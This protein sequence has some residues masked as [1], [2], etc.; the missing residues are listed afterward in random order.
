MG[1]IYTTSPWLTDCRDKR[2]SLAGFFANDQTSE[3]E[4]TKMKNDITKKI[5]L[6]GGSINESDRWDDS[7]THVVAFVNANKDGMS[8]KVRFAFYD[9]GMF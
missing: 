5:I 4:I 1:D 8:E 9:L 7:I 6:L 2:F 3:E